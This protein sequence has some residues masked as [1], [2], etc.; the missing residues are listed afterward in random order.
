[1]SAK[2]PILVVGLGNRYRGDDAIG[3]VVAER[4]R[5]EFPDDITVLSEIPDGAVLIEAW[6]GASLC[7]VTDCAVSGKPAG[8][9]HRFNALERKLPEKLFSHFSTHTFNLSQAVELGKILGKL[10]EQLKV[11][12]IEGSNFRAGEEP[13]EEILRAADTVIAEIKKA[14]EAERNAG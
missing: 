13:G 5:A 10:P 14:I 7:C 8:T 1:M 6:D 2:A 12:G 9:I 11:F 3:I 4:I